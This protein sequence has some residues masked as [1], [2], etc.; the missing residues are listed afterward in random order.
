MTVG[1]AI[2]GDLDDVVE[3]IQYVFR[4]AETLV[5]DD[6]TSPLDEPVVVQAV[7]VR[8]L[9]QTDEPITLDAKLFEHRRQ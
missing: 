6:Q 9:F 3:Q 8:R 4:K 2:R 7:R 1:Q 5:A